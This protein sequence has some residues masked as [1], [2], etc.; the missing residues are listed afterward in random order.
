[1]LV[2]MPPSGVLG[3]GYWV[4]RCHK[5]DQLKAIT[6]AN[7]LRNT[8]KVLCVG[9]EF[10]TGTVVPEDRSAARNE[11]HAVQQRFTSTESQSVSRSLRSRSATPHTWR[12]CSAVIVTPRF[13]TSAP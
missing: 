1:M 9:H 5:P 12:D 10:P 2:P 8:G 6:Y 13:A 3:I 4:M 11:V 7:Q